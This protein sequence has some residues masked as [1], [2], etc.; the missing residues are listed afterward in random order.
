MPAVSNL[1]PVLKTCKTFIQK[2]KI[3][4]KNQPIMRLSI[5]RLSLF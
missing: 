4:T 2:T 3:K 1:L 5:S